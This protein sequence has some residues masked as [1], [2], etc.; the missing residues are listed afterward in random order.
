MRKKVS[1][2]TALFIGA[3]L[4][5]SM[6]VLFFIMNY[7]L[8][9]TLKDNAIK[10]MNVIARD[11]S[12]LVETYIDGCIDFL[13]SYSRS[14][15]A[16][17]VLQNPEDPEALKEAREYTL[18]CATDY[19]YLEGLYVAKWDTYVLAH[20]NPDSMD[21]TF[22]D[23]ASAKELEDMIREAGKPFCTGIV[24]A[25]VTKEM[26][27]PVYAPVFDENGEAIGFAGCAFRTVDLAKRLET[28]NEESGQSI[29]YS[30]INAKNHVYIFNDEP[31][32]MGKE[33][34]DDAI[35]DAVTKTAKRGD[36]S[37]SDFNVV[38]SCHYMADRDWVFIIMD[39]TKGVFE[40]VNSVRTRVLVILVIVTVFMILICVI[41][42][43]RQMRPLRVI[44]KVIVRLKA[45]D[46][47]RDH[48]LDPYLT[49]ED[50]F[51]NISVAV[52]ELHSVL[53]NQYELFL[54]MLKVQRVGTL[55]IKE[56]TKEIV[57]INDMA[58]SLLGFASGTEKLIATSDIWSKV[59]DEE[60]I[61]VKE[62]LDNI[63]RTKQEAAFDVEVRQ[64]GENRIYIL[65]HANYVTL[66]NGDSVI[67]FSLMNITDR[68]KLED[69]LM[70]L[71]ETDGLTGI[72]NR[73]SGER[74]VGSAL[75]SKTPGMFCLFDVDKF[76]YVNDN[77]GHAAGDLVLSGIADVMKKTFRTS[78]ILIRLGGDEFVVFAAD[79]KDQ[80]T[81]QMVIERFLKNIEKLDIEQ[82]NGHHIS[83]S[84]GAVL[85]GS[86]EE[87][88]TLYEKA[89]SLMYECKNK[90][91]NAYAFYNEQ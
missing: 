33:C 86:E 78:D 12:G 16:I 26:V 87:F 4:V 72:C 52:N 79:I 70:L 45:S 32:M 8:T 20:L 58:L 31:G 82:L 55:V 47:T 85:V 76:K 9:A 73:R 2:K 88:S 13:E 35:L 18:R 6:V 43:D 1:I 59:D 69:H 14:E 91:G 22:R 68:K 42:I 5:V 29:G 46:Y 44:N 7:S 51:G 25:P 84:L 39:T 24:L 74:R 66:S 23:P 40:V 21:Q 3:A 62:Q 61:H 50:E 37:F 19:D 89:D 27:I 64:S 34:I 54:E 57:L 30:L 60:K 49:R 83:V 65:A 10:D 75:A 56:D 90:T 38:A 41:S 71:S 53:E 36:Y 28:L 81:G 80:A 11:R 15:E 67:I 63:I 77:F 48:S 17:R